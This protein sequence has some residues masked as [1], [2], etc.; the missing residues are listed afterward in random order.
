MAV[1]GTS[2]RSYAKNWVGKVEKTTDVSW[3][4][5][6]VV[7]I[8]PLYSFEHVAIQ[9]TYAVKLLDCLGLKYLQACGLAV[10]GVTGRRLGL[11][12][13]GNNNNMNTI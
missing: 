6:H 11:N 1:L 7:H 4:H 10:I 2:S 13:S 8:A 12:T 5:L 3:H 9:I